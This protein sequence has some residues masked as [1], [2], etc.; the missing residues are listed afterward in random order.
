M[1]ATCLLV[2]AAILL[3]SGEATAQEVVDTSRSQPARL[4]PGVPELA[5]DPAISGGIAVSAL[6]LAYAIEIGKP[7]IAP[8]VCRWC[9]RGKDGESVLNGVDRSVRKAL[10]WK[11]PI[12]AARISDVTGLALAPGLAFGSIAVAEGADHAAPA[13]PIDALVIFEASAVALAA[14]QVMKVG[15]A[16]TR[17]F[18]HARDLDEP[19]PTPL[20]NDEHLSFPSGHTS[21]AMSVACASGTVAS[22]RRYSLAPAV[23]SV[24]IPLALLTGYLRIGADLHYFTDVLG[25]AVLGALSGVL[26]P[27]V[28]HPPR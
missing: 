8:P 2:A 11:S 19:S 10:V 15:F 9:D 4:P 23:W 22:M 13:F 26:V 7:W 12:V 21:L 17:P 3:G 1:R 27:L 6:S 24:G 5:R 14:T 16:R 20:S 18:A 25:G 28:F